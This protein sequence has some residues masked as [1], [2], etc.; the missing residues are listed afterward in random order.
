V[1]Q[2]IAAKAAWRLG[3]VGRFELSCAGEP[4]HL[5][6]SA[7]RVLGFL[8]LQERS[9]SRMHVAF[10]LWA[11]ASEIHAYGSLRSALFRLQAGGCKLVTASRD[12]LELAPLVAVDLHERLALAEQLLSGRIDEI[13]S[14]IDPA[15]LVDE[16]LPDCYEDWVLLERARY[17]ELRLRALEALC[18]HE[19]LADRL[20][21]AVA[22][23]QAAV[24]A[25]PLRDSARRALIRAYLAEGNH[26]DAL[27]EYRDFELLLHDQLG[28]APS[29]ELRELVAG[30]TDR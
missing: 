17:H 2:L 26:A 1:Q 9:Q 24:R 16:L 29:G 12:E 6:V 8:A 15:L 27:N 22:A 7:Q 28:L 10:T 30:L 5:P 3:L 18:N 4:V 11:G 23:G 19:L 13:P 25:D 21:Q 20:P 14:E